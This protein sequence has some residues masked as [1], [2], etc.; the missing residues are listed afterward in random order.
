MSN[1]KFEIIVCKR[2]E[3]KNRYSE[4]NLRM[5]QSDAKY[6][7]YLDENAQIINKNYINEIIEIF[8]NN[9][10]IGIIGCSGAEVLSTNGIALRS[11]K[12]C[13]KF[14]LKNNQNLMSWSEVNDHYKEVEAVDG[15]FMATQYDIPW[16][17]DLF[18]EDS[19]GIFA[20]TSQ[21]VE[22]KRRGYKSVVV[23]QAEPWLLLNV[24]NFSIDKTSQEKFLKEYSRD[25]FPLVSVIIPTYNR[26]KYFS[27]ALESALNQTYRNIEIFVSDNS[28]DEQTKNLIA[29][30]IE[31]DSRIKYEYHPDFNANDNW[32][33]CRKYNNPN[34][35]YVNWLMDDDIFYSNKLEI[36]V[37][38]FRN[39]PNVSLVTSAR[40]QIDVDGKVTG[41]LG[42]DFKEQVILDGHAIGKDAL[43]N[44][45]NR[46]GEPTTVLIKKNCLRDNDLCWSDDEQGFFSLI[47]L[48]TWLQ[49]LT[50]GDMG[51]YPEPLSAL[52]VHNDMTSLQSKTYV[53]FWVDWAKLIW[54][55]WH[56]KT[57][58]ETKEEIRA[59]ILIWLHHA[60]LGLRK[61]YLMNYQGDELAELER[62][63]LETFKAVENSYEMEYKIKSK[64][65]NR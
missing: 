28:K 30:Y 12:R 48:S 49:L 58:L 9:K 11:A 42:L 21:C 36:M 46:I 26:P 44:M 35:E 38:I 2:N 54:T 51:F 59:A 37:E 33:N 29:D 45:T 34:A 17:D 55:G 20:F 57:F 24:Q 31:A 61:A 50:K 23:N 65:L 19:D 16:R 27:L 4:Y 6:K 10:G 47:D 64:G 5:S 60:S 7:I 13:G 52:R 53:T 32:N 3:V 15:F 43:F 18:T 8:K 56:K 41:N 1:D 40:H 22:F 25:V 39:N 63:M 62:L 14:Y